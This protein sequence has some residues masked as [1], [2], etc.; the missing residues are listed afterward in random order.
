[1]D[2]YYVIGQSV[3]Y[4]HVAIIWLFAL[5]EAVAMVRLSRVEMHLS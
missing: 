1:M 5:V 3:V 4:L 2:E